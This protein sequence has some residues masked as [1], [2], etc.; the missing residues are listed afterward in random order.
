MPL[1]NNFGLI[2]GV[3][4]A[5]T[6]SQIT[7]EEGLDSKGVYERGHIEAWLRR[8]NPD[9]RLYKKALEKLTRTSAAYCAIAYAATTVPLG[10]AGLDV[11]CR[12]AC[13]CSRCTRDPS[14]LY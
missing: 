11:V 12:R 9:E 7:A 3:A 14:R 8:N 10:P 4:N 6:L 2:E 13:Q 1:D 5:L